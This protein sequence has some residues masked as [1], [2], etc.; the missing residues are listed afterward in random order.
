MS[1]LSKDS[2]YISARVRRIHKAQLEELALTNGRNRSSMMRFV[3]E[4]AYRDLYRRPIIGANT[5]VEDNER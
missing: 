1:S 2:V 3:I 4:R 5:D